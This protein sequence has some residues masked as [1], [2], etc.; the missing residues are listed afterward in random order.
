M[1]LPR[2]STGPAVR[3]LQRAL[4]ALG[5]PLPRFGADG[6]LGTETLT[7]L[8][9][10]LHAHGRELAEVPD[11]VTDADLDLVA[12]LLGPRGSPPIVLDDV[13]QL[14]SRAFVIGPRPWTAITGITLHQTACVLG[15]RPERWATIGAHVGVTRGGRVVHMHDFTSTVVHGNGFN[16]RTIGIEMDGMYAGVEGD[17]RTFW[18][19]LT[20]PNRQPQTPTTDLIASARAAIRWIVAEV[21]RHGGRVTRLVAHRQSSKDRQGDPGSALWQAVALPMMAELGLDDGGPGYCVGTG[22]PVPEAW[23]E[24]RVGVRY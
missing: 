22:L 24:R 6:A 23:D 3:D 7:A 21:A 17:P 19:P 2:G 1:T 10:L 9:L 4:V 15:E 12:R 14:A 5:Y 13:R 11:E 18:R 16:A 20:E 8:A